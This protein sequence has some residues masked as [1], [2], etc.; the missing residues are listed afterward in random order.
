[1]KSSTLGRASFR[2]YDKTA[3]KMHY[4]PNCSLLIRN[5]IQVRLPHGHVS[6][7]NHVLMWGANVHDENNEP[8]F[9][10]DV[11]NQTSLW[12]EL[13]GIYVNYHVVHED[14]CYWLRKPGSKHRRRLT[15]RL[16]DRMRMVVIGNSVEYPSL[17]APPLL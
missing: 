12:R 1:M 9:E 2:V 3:K 8:V 14:G 11:L 6:R 4:P 10:K 16:L 17:L 13:F 5:G 7:H 15:Q